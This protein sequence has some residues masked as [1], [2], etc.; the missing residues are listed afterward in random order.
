[1]VNN[2]WV[3]ATT[4]AGKLREFRR[5]FDVLGL[6]LVTMNE[7]GVTDSPEEDGE[8]FEENALI[9]ARACAAACGLPTIAD[10]SGL[11]VDALGGAPGIHSARFDV[12]G[13]RTYR[14]LREMEDV[15]DGQRGA[16]Y[17]CAIACVIPGECEFV[18]AG[19]CFGEI[20]REKVGEN[21]FGYDPIFYCPEFQKTYGE[22]S[23]AE[24]DKISHRG[25]AIE[26]L[27]V[28]LIKRGYLC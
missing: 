8:T 23:D 6:E 19:Q 16:S 4:N 21:G 13:Q 24:K 18:V 17:Y 22:L 25:R 20:I 26:A 2:K 7:L 12:P 28:E 3:L 9:K 27:R 15:P 11:T 14:V 5:M 1:M 10:D